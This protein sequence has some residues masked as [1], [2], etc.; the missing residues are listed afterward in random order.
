MDLKSVKLGYPLANF[1]DMIGEEK[2]L[3]QELRWAREAL[4][5]L[6]YREENGQHNGYEQEIQLIPI[7]FRHYAD[8]YYEELQKHV[9]RLERDLEDLQ[10]C[11][12]RQ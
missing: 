8:Q 1:L 9:D 4:S 3:K 5:V 7:E 12:V 11:E 6:E 2:L 10:N